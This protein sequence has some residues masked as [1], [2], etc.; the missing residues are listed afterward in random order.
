MNKRLEKAA[1]CFMRAAEACLHPARPE[2][3][4]TWATMGVVHL[5]NV[6]G[7]AA[8]AERLV[9]RVTS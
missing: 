1:V 8:A 6:K 4:L 5:G 3:A 2:I 9:R 7:A